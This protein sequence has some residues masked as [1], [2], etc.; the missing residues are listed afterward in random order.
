MYTYMYTGG[1]GD[2]RGSHLSNTTCPTRVLF[3]HVNR[4]AD[5]GDP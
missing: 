3:E 4:F 5:R 1:G 2:A